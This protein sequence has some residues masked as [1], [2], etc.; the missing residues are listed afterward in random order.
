MT[1]EIQRAARQVIGHWYQGDTMDEDGLGLRCG[2]GH[3]LDVLGLQV[4]AE[5][6]GPQVPDEE[7]IAERAR[8]MILCM[9][10]AAV[11]KFPDRGQEGGASF[12]AFNDHPD[13]V[14]EEVAAVM[15]LAGERWAIEHDQCV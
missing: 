11:D 1:N 14:E 12:V 9:D 6:T 2:I 10:Q 15:E 8:L 4:D 3:L 5:L 7:A 13:T